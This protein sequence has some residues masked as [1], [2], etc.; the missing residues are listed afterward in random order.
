M[1]QTVV[2][3]KDNAVMHKIVKVPK[4]QLAEWDATHDVSGRPITTE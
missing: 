1:R 3:L 2:V 4:G